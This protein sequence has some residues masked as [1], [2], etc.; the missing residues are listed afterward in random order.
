MPMHREQSNPQQQ[1]ARQDR[2]YP[3]AGPAGGEFCPCWLRLAIQEPIL[4]KKNESEFDCPAGKVDHSAGNSKQCDTSNTLVS[5]A[6]R[7]AH[8]IMPPMDPF[9]LGNACTAASESEYAQVLQHTAKDRPDSLGNNTTQH[10]CPPVVPKR[11]SS[12]PTSSSFP[13]PSMRHVLSGKHSSSFSQVLD[14]LQRP[15]QSGSFKKPQHISTSPTTTH[16]AKK[17]RHDSNHV[18]SPLSHPANAGNSPFRPFLVSSFSVS[19]EKETEGN[20]RCSSESVSG[21]CS[22]LDDSEGTTWKKRY[23]ALFKE[24]SQV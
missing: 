5:H 8:S 10:Q 22:P 18:Q 19:A 12:C 1:Q 7:V 11:L 23:R 16:V 9:G 2:F 6:G 13:K 24:V 21:R 17:D 4:T 3:H 15:T 14:Q 20:A